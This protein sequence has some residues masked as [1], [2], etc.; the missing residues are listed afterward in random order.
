MDNIVIGVFTNL[1]GW[2]YLKCFNGNVPILCDDFSSACHYS[3][4]YCSEIKAA[5]DN[6]YYMGYDAFYFIDLNAKEEEN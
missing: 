1:S 4:C 6:L 3:S 2:Q 5:Y